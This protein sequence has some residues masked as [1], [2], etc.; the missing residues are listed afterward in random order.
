MSDAYLLESI[1]AAARKAYATEQF[2]TILGR[3]VT[4]PDALGE[5]AWTLL[6]RRE[7]RDA[8]R[9]RHGNVSTEASAL[10]RLGLLEYPPLDDAVRALAGATPVRCWPKPF[11]FAACLTHDVDDV[12]P[13]PW[14]ERWRRLREPGLRASMAQCLRWAGGALGYGLGGARGERSPFDAWMAEEARFGFHSTFFVMPEHYA[15]P[16][17][18]DHYHGYG[19]P[20]WYFGE[21]MTY[22][23]AA[24]RAAAAGWEIGLHGG[25]AS[26]LEGDMLHAEKTRLEAMLGAP[27]TAGRQHYLRFD[28]DVTPAVWA[29]AGLRAD[30][31]MGSTT[32]LGYRAGLSFPYFWPGAGD[33]LEVPLAVHDI[34]LLRATDGDPLAQ[35]RAL[36]ERVARLGGVVALSWHTH[37][38]SSRAMT[39][40]RALLQVI[41]DLGGWGCTV[42]EVN[43]WWRVRRAAVRAQ[44]DV[45]EQ[46]VDHAA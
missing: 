28:I 27:V 32:R 31:T 16:T 45:V 33:I 11:R 2:A 36:L 44:R 30:S 22:A 29:R 19:D 24:R 46:E 14:R 8:V 17:P 13:C 23:E 20:V 1:H 6:S 18:Y 12:V 42:S 35:A 25:Y 43:T 26:A 9:D 34:C 15:R 39:C 38:V 41:A 21:R 4:V 7:E 5:L 10:A 3:P 40:Y 37:P